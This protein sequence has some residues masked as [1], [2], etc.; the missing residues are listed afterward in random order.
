[1][2][3]PVPLF[4]APFEKGRRQYLWA[5]NRHLHNLT[6]PSRQQNGSPE[7]SRPSQDRE[8]I[9]RS[10]SSSH[11]A[12]SCTLRSAASS[13]GEARGEMRETWDP[14]WVHLGLAPRAF[15]RARDPANLGFT[16]HCAVDGWGVA[17]ESPNIE[18]AANLAEEDVGPP[19]PLADVDKEPSRPRSERAL[20]QRKRPGAV[21]VGAPAT[22]TPSGSGNS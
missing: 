12:I 17:L 3:I 8:K 20:G 10:T 13:A 5:A 16:R 18:S 7:H 22:L 21:E 1:M 2:S 15:Q 4:Q 11:K 14:S 9:G 6:Q 19:G